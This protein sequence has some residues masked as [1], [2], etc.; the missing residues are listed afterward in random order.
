[1][2]IIAKSFKITQNLDLDIG[3]VSSALTFLDMYLEI[4]QILSINFLICEYRARKNNS[5]C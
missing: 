5:L 2:L 3:C 4:S 1:M